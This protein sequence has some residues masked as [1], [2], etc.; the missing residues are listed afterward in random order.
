M[1][2]P[3]WCVI[4]LE[5]ITYS[6]LVCHLYIKSPKKHIDVFQ[7]LRSSSGNKENFEL[8]DG[9]DNRKTIRG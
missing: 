1:D 9:S 8:S 5:N 4:S 7:I 6:G 3:V 2:C